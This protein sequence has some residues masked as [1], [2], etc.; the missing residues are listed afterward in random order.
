LFWRIIQKNKLWLQYAV[1]QPRMIDM[2]YSIITYLHEGRKDISQLGF[3]HLLVQILYFLSSQRELAL[4]M[5]NPFNRKITIDIPKF[6]AGTY[7]DYLFVV[8]FKIVRDSHKKLKYLWEC[9]LTIITNISPYVQGISKLTSSKLLSLF[10][11]L[12]N[13]KFLFRKDKNHRYCFYLVEA[14]NNILQYQYNS[15][16]FL[17]YDIIH[18]Q[19]LFI[20]LNNLKKY[21]KRR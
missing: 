17:V 20:K 16:L 12:T 1:Q 6:S 3:M 7:V 18:H 8:L 19:E 4:Q 11:A 10:K 13:P 5:N 15:N 14:F 21:N 9:C 2:I